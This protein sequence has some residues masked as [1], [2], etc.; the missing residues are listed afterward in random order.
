MTTEKQIQANRL[1]ALKAGVKTEQ[2]K[3][4][5]RY[6]AVSHGFF[7]KSLLMPGE[8]RSL[9]DTFRDRF[10]DELKPEGELETVLVER[11]VS[12]AW[13]L[14]RMLGVEVKRAPA[15]NNYLSSHWQNLMRYET[16]LERQIYKALHELVVLQSARLKQ[17]AKVNY[18]KDMAEINAL[19]TEILSSRPENP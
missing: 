9:L 13:R 5:V 17:Q 10:M 3:A 6:N 12:S 16:T 7:S 19:Q 1:N 8:E 15:G 14:R 11:M 18:A 4:A 2:G